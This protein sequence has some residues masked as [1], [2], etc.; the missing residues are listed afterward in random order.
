[1]GEQTGL[2]GSATYRA[3]QGDLD[4]IRAIGLSS[5]GGKAD[6]TAELFLQFS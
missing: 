6:S 2:T 4:K 3:F 5:T 1:L